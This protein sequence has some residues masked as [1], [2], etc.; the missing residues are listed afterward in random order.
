MADEIEEQQPDA[1]EEPEEQEAGA[2]LSK[3]T[4]MIGAAAFV[5]F[6]IVFL[7]MGGAFSSKPQPV[8]EKAD[9]PAV[10]E[11]SEKHT[12]DSEISSND[13]H[14]EYGHIGSNDEEDSVKDS[15][16]SKEDSLAQMKWYEIQQREIDAERV[17]IRT[18]QARLEQLR[19]E[20]QALLQRR[21]DLEQTNISNMAKLFETMRP[22]EVANIM[23]NMP[24]SKVGLI[25]QKMKKSSAS[26]VMA[27]LPS[28]RAAKITLEL[29]DLSGEF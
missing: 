21:N 19:M 9:K 24:D 20:T 29:I 6:V 23:E 28:E 2:P 5:V 25:L 17:R 26:E 18:E 7:V 11:A 1:V 4:I 12:D 27:N 22:E 10:A 13:W 15:V 14:A 8:A 3:Q 16:M